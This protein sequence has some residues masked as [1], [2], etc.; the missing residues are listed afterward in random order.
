MSESDFSVAVVI[1]IHRMHDYLGPCIDSVLAQTL[2]AK[3]IIVVNDG[4]G[5]TINDYVRTHYPMCTLVD[6]VN[7]RGLPGARN[8][9]VAHCETEWLS[10]LDSDDLFEPE[11]FAR[12]SAWAAAS[13]TEILA[14]HCG[15]QVFGSKGDKETLRQQTAAAVAGASQVS[16][17]GTVFEFLDSP[18]PV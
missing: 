6:L 17:P 9:G 13:E 5:E 3:Q 11:K 16:Q 10:F 14:Y 15:L 4:G 2:P 1:P 12:E 7:N 18:R 8:A